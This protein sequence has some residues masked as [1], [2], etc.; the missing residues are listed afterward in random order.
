MS[1]IISDL[2][3][4][5]TFINP[6]E[7][8]RNHEDLYLRYYTY[9]VE[10]CPTTGRTH[11]Q[12]VM[13]LRDSIARHEING[14]IFEYSAHLE[15]PRSFLGAVLYSNKPETRVSGPITFRALPLALRVSEMELERDCLELMS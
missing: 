12:G 8:L 1:N 9:Q 15:V 3:M 6:Q 10:S 11:Y 5:T 14:M 2:W 13:L 7:G 4:F